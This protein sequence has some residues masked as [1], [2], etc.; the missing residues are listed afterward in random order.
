MRLIQQ[1]ENQIPKMSEE[2][3]ESPQ[4]SNIIGPLNFTNDKN[5][6]ESNFNS[7]LRTPIEI[8]C[9]FCDKSFQFYSEKDEYLAH[10]YLDH[11]LI[12]GDEDQVAIF[13]EY[14]IFWREK[15]NGDEQKLPEYCTMMIMDQLPDGTPAKGEKYY[16]LC[17]V[18]PQDNELRQKLQQKRLERALAQHQFERTDTN[19]QG[20][21]LFCRDVI[22]TSRNDLLEHLFSKH[23][24]QLGKPEN[25]VFIDELIDTVQSK[26]NNLVCLFCE[27]KF[28]DRPT[29]KEHMRKKGHKRINPG[30]KSYDRFFLINYQLET[31]T[32]QKKKAKHHQRLRKRSENDAKMEKDPTVRPIE[33]SSNEA[34]TASK[35]REKKNASTLFESDSDS[36]WSDWHGDQ[37]T[38]TCLFCSHNEIDF[39]KLKVHMAH[40]H[41]VDFDN[42]TASMTFYDR[43]KIVNFIRRKMYL[44]QCIRCDEQFKKSADLRAH[45][46]ESNHCCI[47]DRK[48]WDLPQYF[49]PTYEDDGI[50]CSLDDTELDEESCIS[51]TKAEDSSIVVLSEDAK[52][53]INLD[54][55]AL[56]KERLQVL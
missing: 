46:N 23:F 52:V 48:Q 19:F 17:D 21:C 20:D 25:L 49:F 29:L 32:S 11:R 41:Q 55:E 34:T 8:R 38:L 18:L 47:G 51:V 35:Y 39:S 14:L 24:L 28:R 16:L 53:S 1:K 30:N 15:F 5:S 2:T 13:H 40:S 22:K 4:T 31:Q 54:A 27:K 6:E 26:L 3:E 50:L 44:S 43:V 42:E 56:S 45:L 12:I 9:L 36:N 7:L 33:G 10:L 37:E